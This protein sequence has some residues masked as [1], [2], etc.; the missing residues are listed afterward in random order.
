MRGVSFVLLL[1]VGC[2]TSEI[3]RDRVSAV[4]PVSASVSV[5]ESPPPPP[6]AP[7][8]ASDLTNDDVAALVLRD[9]DRATHHVRTTAVDAGFG[10]SDAID[11]VA[12]NGDVVHTFVDPSLGAGGVHVERLRG[13]DWAKSDLVAWVVV[14][15]Q[16]GMCGFGQGFLALVEGRT[17][18]AL[19]PWSGSCGTPYHASFLTAAGRGALLEE[20]DENGGED[21]VGE[22]SDRVWLV[23]GARWKLAGN[24]RREQTENWVHATPGWDSKMDSTVAGDASGIV[25]NER[26]YFTSESTQKTTDRTRTLRYTLR[27][28]S[29]VVPRNPAPTP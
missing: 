6:P 3:A 23:S 25:V 10:V 7:P 5:A 14:G 17:V 26:W 18:R 2:R 1:A 15:M 21:G 28:D 27:G 9:F 8:Q 29:L 12:S 4:A 24:V 19:A 11:V 22:V 20:E 16:P 13:D